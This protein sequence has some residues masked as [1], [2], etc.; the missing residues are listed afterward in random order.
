M[1][2]K[3]SRFDD[4]HKKLIAMIGQLND[5][6]QHGQSEKVIH[7]IL[8][9]LTSYCKEHFADE[10]RFLEEHGYPGL[11]EHKQVHVAFINKVSE[12]VRDYGE[13]K[14]SPSQVMNLLSDWLMSHILKTDKKYGEFFSS[15]GGV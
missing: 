10:E 15:K 2:V 6:L 5:A 4:A 8:Q 11:Q 12:V 9:G 14:A 3:V 1:T 7:E 13:H